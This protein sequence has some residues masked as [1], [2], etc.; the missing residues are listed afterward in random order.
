MEGDAGLGYYGTRYRAIE[1]VLIEK[2]ICT[3]VDINDAVARQEARTPAD[4]ARVIAHAWSDPYFKARFIDDPLTAIAELGYRLPDN[5]VETPKLTVL[6]NTEGIHHLVVCTLCSCYPGTLLGN[7]PD[8]YKSLT[9]RSR[10]VKDPRGVMHEFG[11]DLANEVE[12]R[13]QDSTADLRYIV[14][15]KRPI[16]TEYMSEE[17]LAKLITRDSMIGVS[18]ALEPGQAST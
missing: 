5:V 3:L 10:A 6:E 15:P 9:Y 1:A 11:L 16:G 14:M 7:P 4:G 12:V 2:G 8:W 18:G 13:V 17:E